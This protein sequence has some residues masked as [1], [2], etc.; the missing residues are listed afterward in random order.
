MRAD[1]GGLFMESHDLDMEQY[2]RRDQFNYFRTLAYP[3]AGMTVN[4]DITGLMKHL[5]SEGLPF[6]L[7]ALYL[8]AR[9]ANGIPEFRQRIRGDRVIEFDRCIPSYTLAL[10]KGDYCYCAADERLPYPDYLKDAGR[11][12]EKARVAKRI[13]DDEDA[14][15]LFFF[16][17]VPWVSYT[18][19]LQPVPIP[20]DSNPRITWGRYFTSEG[21]VKLPV[22]LLVNHALMDGY[23]MAAFFNGLEARC[24]DPKEL[25]V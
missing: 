13:Q 22:S 24:A 17:S 9:T 10:E 11:R 5:K 12:Q 19:I 4:V 2:P 20:A 8:A 1:G 6:Y 14:E 18:A 25:F 21:R 7:T 3:Y 23:Q 16:S 15:Q